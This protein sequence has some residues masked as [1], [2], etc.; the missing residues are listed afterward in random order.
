MTVR[1]RYNGRKNTEQWIKKM[2]GGYWETQRGCPKNTLVTIREDN[3]IFFGIARY[4]QAYGIA[5][6][7]KMGKKIAR[8]RAESVRKTTSGADCTLPETI[9]YAKSGMAGTCNVDSIKLVLNYFDRIEELA[10]QGKLL[11]DMGERMQRLAGVEGVK[12]F[13]TSLIPGR[14]KQTIT[15]DHERIQHLTGFNS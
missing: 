2:S 12:N 6:A 7:K 14:K 1:V 9:V 13:P 4:N 10:P 3:R 15:I 11:C 5:F 8:S